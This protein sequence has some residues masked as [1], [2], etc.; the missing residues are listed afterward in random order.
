MTSSAVSIST[1]D[2]ETIAF[3]VMF[4]WVSTAPFGLPVVPDV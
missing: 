4:S 2:E 3:M 1:C